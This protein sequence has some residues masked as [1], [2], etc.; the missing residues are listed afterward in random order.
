MAWPQDEAPFNADELTQLQEVLGVSADDLG[1]ALTACSFM[2][3]QA[4][5]FNV[6]AK[7]LA[8][9]LMKAEVLQDKVRAARVRARARAPRSRMGRDLVWPPR[10]VRCAQAEMF[11]QVWDKNGE[12]V[13]GRLQ[14][15]SLAPQQ[16][17]AVDWRLQIN[18]CVA[19]ISS[20]RGMNGR[21]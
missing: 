21:R 6:K 2:F 11:F 19:G 17:T 14:E 15:H 1:L 16:L 10:A 8:S 3:Q 12:A 7:R 13:I 20:G 9:Q 5:Y 4:A 18:M